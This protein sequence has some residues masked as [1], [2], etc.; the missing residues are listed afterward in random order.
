MPWNK[1]SLVMPFF[2]DISRKDIFD[3]FDLTKTISD[4]MVAF[5]M[6][7]NKLSLLMPCFRDISHQDIFGSILSDWKYISFYGSIYNAMK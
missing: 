2:R 4:F 7:W 6:P 5:T 1:L 3:I